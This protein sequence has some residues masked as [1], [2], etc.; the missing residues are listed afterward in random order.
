M[1]FFFFFEH[2]VNSIGKPP[3]GPTMVSARVVRFEVEDAD[4]RGA[5]NDGGIRGRDVSFPK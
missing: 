5:G 1:F 2:S 4:F 3:P